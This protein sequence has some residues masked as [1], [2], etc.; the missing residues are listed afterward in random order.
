MIAVRIFSFTARYARV[1]PMEWML[2]NSIGQAQFAEGSGL[3]V[4]Q[5]HRVTCGQFSNSAGF[6]IC[7]SK[8]TKLIFDQRSNIFINILTSH[9]RITCIAM[10]KVRLY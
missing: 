9:K 5:Q 1:T 6:H 7:Y 4:L 8:A 2:R 10:K 3:N